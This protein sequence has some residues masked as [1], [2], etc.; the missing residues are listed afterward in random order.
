[1]SALRNLTP[2]E[3]M[4]GLVESFHSLANAKCLDARGEFSST[5]FAK[6]ATRALYTE[7]ELDCARFVLFVWNSTTR[8]KIGK[9]DFGQA[10]VR[11]DSQNRAAFIAW[12]REPW[13]V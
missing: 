2:T 12:A 3:R 7:A 1:V 5:T 4:L 10:I 8:W 9:F 13:W 6:W 11:W